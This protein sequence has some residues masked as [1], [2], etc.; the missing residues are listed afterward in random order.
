MKKKI[1]LFLILTVFLLFSSCIQNNANIKKNNVGQLSI[2]LPGEYIDPEL[3]EEFSKETGIKVKIENFENNED[4]FVK[5]QHGHTDYD[6]VVA[7]DYM[8][9]KMIKLDMLEKIDY[10]KLKNYKYIDNYFK[11]MKF[12]INNEYNVP[13]FYGYVGILYNKKYID[14][15][16]DSWN[17]LFDEKYKGKILMLNST[18]DSMMIALKTLGYSMN[19]IDENEI[20]EAINLLISQKPLVLA[21]GLDDIREEM[22]N[23]SAWLLPTYNGE[24]IDLGR[25]NDD[26]ELSIPKEGTNVWVDSMVILKESKNIDLIYKFIDFI[27]EPKNNAKNAEF[28]GYSTPNKGALDFISPE[29]RNNTK[30]YPN[31]S[32]FKN[33]EE[34]IDL[35][36]YIKLYNDAWILLKAN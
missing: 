31:L 26:L 22:L 5:I 27:L 18:R 9:E 34:F 2:Y 28:V 21:Y 10:L 17:I 15:P 3:I 13:Y 36:D 32:E 33:C 23:E 7:S 11:N 29:I 25:E 4:M 30:A 8:I 1:I 16:V 12:D 19:T 14:E 20:N 6:I 35:D 24:I